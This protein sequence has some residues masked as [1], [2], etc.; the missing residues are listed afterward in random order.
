M[1]NVGF[2]TKSKI[3]LKHSFFDDV[4]IIMSQRPCLTCAV[5]H[6][7]MDSRNFV[8]KTA[9]S[10]QNIFYDSHYVLYVVSIIHLLYD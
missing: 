4:K 8:N 2:E 6:T 5:V 1:F 9:Y 10:M 3:L 7:L